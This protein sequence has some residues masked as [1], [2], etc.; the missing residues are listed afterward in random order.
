M[1]YS[2]PVSVASYPLLAVALILLGLLFTAGYFVN[3]M[4]SGNK[5]IVLELIIAV[6][7]SFAL[8]FGTFFLML[9][10]GLYV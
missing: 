3:Q 4:R 5:S 1:A 9:S 10:F 2:S 8:G 7:A 6:F